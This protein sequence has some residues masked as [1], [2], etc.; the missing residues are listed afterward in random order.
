MNSFSWD[1]FYD[2]PVVGILRG[3]GDD[4]VRNIVAASSKG[5]L[6]NIEI[7]MNTKNAPDLIKLAIETAKGQMNVGAGTVRT[8]DELNTA[9][10][11][12]AGFVV[13]PICNGEIIKCCSQKNVPVFPGAFTPTEVYNAWQAGA[14][15][16]KLFPANRMGPGYLKDLKGPLSE[17]K[18][19][20]T[21]GVRVEN[22]HEYIDCGA[23]AF[24]V[25][26]PLFDKNKI[27]AADWNWITQQAQKFT[28]TYRT[29]TSQWR[30]SKGK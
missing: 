18:L 25:G 9:L 21:G 11:A 14:D 7:T 2:L 19:M 23:S 22:L 4:D 6:R 3:F 20:P 10:D 26:T 1:V 17:I 28:K 30:A 29:H 5:G 12:G 16:V 13:T 24:G 8:I 15:M 27:A